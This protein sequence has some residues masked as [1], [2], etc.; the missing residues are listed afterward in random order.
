MISICDIGA[1]SGTGD[2]VDNTVFIDNLINNS[3]CFLYGF[4]PNQKEFEK[5]MPQ[6]NKKYFNY[7]IGNGNDEILNIYKA[8]GM[9]S[10]LE[11]DLE[12][13][14]FFENFKEWC[15]IVEKIPIKTKKLDEVTFDSKIDFIKIDVQGYESEIIKFGQNTLKNS[16]LINIEVSPIPLYKNEKNFSFIY[17]QLNNLGFVLHA[18]NRIE[19]RCFKPMRLI[20]NNFTGIN[21]LLQLDCIFIK[22]FEEIK[23]YNSENLKKLAMILF[24]SFNS[25]DLVDLIIQRISEIDSINYINKYREIVKDLKIKKIY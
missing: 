14:N 20:D 3:N 10:I 23:K 12:Y 24:F 8:P 5:L 16:L 21:H 7:G 22:N 19:T 25:Y 1:K 13:L 11:P 9:C 6:D 4:E 15:D 18:F 2:D 17:N